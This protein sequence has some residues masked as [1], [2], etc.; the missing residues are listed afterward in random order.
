[1]SRIGA[2][3]NSRLDSRTNRSIIQLPMNY[4]LD[5]YTTV[6]DAVTHSPDSAFETT[7]WARNQLDADKLE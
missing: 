4:L 2:R 3:P 5:Q 1:M 6:V 7:I